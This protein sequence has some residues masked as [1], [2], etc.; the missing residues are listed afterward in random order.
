MTDAFTTFIEMFGFQADQIPEPV[1]AVI[2]LVLMVLFLS[3]FC[4]IFS[5]MFPKR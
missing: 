1:R 4:D 3:A 5:Y 2:A